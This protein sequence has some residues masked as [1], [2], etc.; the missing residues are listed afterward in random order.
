MENE[1]KVKVVK[2]FPSFY[3]ILKHGY[4]QYYTPYELS[5]IKLY[6]QK[7]EL[8]KLPSILKKSLGRRIYEIETLKR[9]M[10]TA[11]INRPLPGRPTVRM[12]DLLFSVMASGLIAYILFGVQGNLFPF[13]LT[14]VVL[15]LLLYNWILPGLGKFFSLGRLPTQNND[16]P[17]LIVDNSERETAPFIDATGTRGGALLGDVKHDPFQTGGLGTPAHLRVE[18]GAIHK[19]H[20]GILF[21]D[22]IGTM[23][24]DLQQKI[25]TAMQEKKFPITGQ[26][27]NSAGALVKTEPVPTDFVLV[28]SGNPEDIKGIHPALRSRI[29]GA[30]YEVYMDVD[31]PDTPE[32][33]YKLAV[34]VAQEVKKDGK[35]PHFTRGAVEEIIKIARELADR[36]NYLTLRLRE[37]G[38]IVRAAGDIALKEGAEL[39]ESYHVL[40]AKK[41]ALTA[42]Q[43]S[44][45]KYIERTKEYHIHKT[46]GEEVGR[47]NGLAV[48]EDQG[49]VLKGIVM[50]IEALVTPALN[51]NSPQVYATGGLRKIAK[52]AVQNVMAIVKKAFGKNLAKK[53]VHIQFVQSY[54]TEGDSA[55]IAVAV[56][57]IS[58]LF[59]IPV[60]QDIAMTGSL[61][62]R[63]RVL[64]VGGVNKKIEAAKELGLKGVIIPKVLMKDVMVEGIEI[65]PVETLSEV[66]DISLVG[67]DKEKIVERIKA[68]EPNVISQPALPP[69][70]APQ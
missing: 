1:P 5:Q 56:A 57:T 49:I 65:Y 13:A 16:A 24:I 18:A 4:Q 26:S 39:V 32:N 19:A 59:N 12:K 20:K 41:R 17:K 7:G 69:R 36:K 51:P 15:T 58:A 9:K 10:A 46:E 14:T 33:R 67:K 27:E 63:G 21:I 55:S 68:I 38:G 70:S 31:M 42:E 60:R 37:L 29:R 22:E 8:H 23:P 64:P 61:D 47:V 25:L 35:I 11:S 48:Y 52:E 28:A 50:P 44:I 53:D 54:N 3:Y 40:E 34:F 30:G 2:S 6:S 66:L 62:I 43:Q 45:M